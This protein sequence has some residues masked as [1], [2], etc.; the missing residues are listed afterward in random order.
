MQCVKGWWCINW[1]ANGELFWCHLMQKYEQLKSKQQSIT[2]NYT[3]FPP[4]S[5]FQFYISRI[6]S[7]LNCYVQI[8]YYGTTFKYSSTALYIQLFLNAKGNLIYIMPIACKRYEILSHNNSSLVK[9]IE[10]FITFH[11]IGQVIT[12]I[13]IGSNSNRF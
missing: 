11:I 6:Y 9:G 7:C 3:T 2:K 13:N 12:S 5:V 1:C 10:A 8:Q 4:T